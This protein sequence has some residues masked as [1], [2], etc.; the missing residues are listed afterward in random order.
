MADSRS[1]LE[2]L[3][4]CSSE[5]KEISSKPNLLNMGLMAAFSYYLLYSVFFLAFFMF[6]EPN[7]RKTSASKKANLIESIR[8][9][10][11][12]CLC[13]FST[14]IKRVFLLFLPSYF[15]FLQ[16]FIFLFSCTLFISILWGCI[17]WRIV[18]VSWKNFDWFYVCL[19]LLL[20]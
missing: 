7:K 9:A 6:T 1:R 20:F 3:F 15:D 12:E 10:I 4:R 17:T 18:F 5:F 19:Y 16:W 11:A 2:L 14:Q 8:K 13:L